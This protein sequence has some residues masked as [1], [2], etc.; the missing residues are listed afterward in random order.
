MSEELTVDE[1][2]RVPAFTELPVVLTVK[3]M[4][5]REWDLPCDLHLRQ[6]RYLERKR[7]HWPKMR[8]AYNDV[9]TSNTTQLCNGSIELLEWQMFQ[10]LERTDHVE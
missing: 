4:F 3:D 6:K 1:G 2:N 7:K 5:L 8:D 9:G 10:D